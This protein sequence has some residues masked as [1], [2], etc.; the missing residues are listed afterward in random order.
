[1]LVHVLIDEEN[2][3]RYRGIKTVK[4][5]GSKNQHPNIRYYIGEDREVY[6]DKGYFK[7]PLP[8]NSGI[9]EPPWLEGL[10]Y[11]F[12]IYDNSVS[13]SPKRTTG[14]Y[15]YKKATGTVEESMSSGKPSYLVRIEGESLKEI[16]ELYA[17]IRRGD[18]PPTESWEK[19]QINPKHAIKY[20][21]RCIW[22]QLKVLF[23]KI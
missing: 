16:H 7:S 10:C 9:E 14:E 5:P 12:T 19:K 6:Y 23:K 8:S 2:A 11:K 22:W 15:K 20:H 18:I 4:I 13:R 21:L 3:R 17:L 1:M